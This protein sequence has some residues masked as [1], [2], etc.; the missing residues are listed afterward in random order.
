MFSLDEIIDLAI[1][2]EENGEK[3]I[4]DAKAKISD[5][6]LSS[7]LQWVGE[8][9]AEHIKWFNQLKETTKE[10]SG[11]HQLEKMGRAILRGLL[12]DQTFSL[13]DADFSKI[14]HV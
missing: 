12:L 6:S 5:P 11:S 3:F 7:I 4:H 1:Q 8:E 14:E 13:Q 9:E 10:T 2:I